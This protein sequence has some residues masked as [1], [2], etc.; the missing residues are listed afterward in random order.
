MQKISHAL[1]AFWNWLLVSSTNPVATS[2]TVKGTLGIVLT[3]F[4][5]I[6]GLVHLQVPGLDANLNSIIDQIVLVVQYFLYF[7]SAVSAI[8]GLVRKVWVSIMSAV[9]GTTPAAPATP[10]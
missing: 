10:Q 4:T 7:V 6:I 5:T 9:K 2:L 3:Y 1:D 8:V